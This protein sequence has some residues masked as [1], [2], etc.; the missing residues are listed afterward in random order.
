MILSLIAICSG[1]GIFMLQRLNS[2]KRG[3]SVHL[4]EFVPKQSR[5]FVYAG[6]LSQII[7]S[8]HFPK[9]YQ[10]IFIAI[11]PYQS[12]R[13]LVV[14]DTADF[15]LCQKVTQQQEQRLK[16]FLNQTVFPL[17]PPKIRNYR[18][19][20]LYFYSGNDSFFVCTF[21]SGTFVGS[22][23]F[24][25]FQS[26]LNA[27]Y[28]KTGF[29]CNVQQQETIASYL[30]AEKAVFISRQ[31]DSFA[32]ITVEKGD[33]W[34]S[35]AGFDTS[36]AIVPNQKKLLFDLDVLPDSLFSLQ[37]GDQIEF[38]FTDAVLRQIQGTSYRL[39]L[40]RG[41]GSVK[42]LSVYPL[43]NHILLI[44]SIN[45]GDAPR[46]QM[47]R[48]PFSSF[49]GIH[50]LYEASHLLKNNNVGNASS[51]YWSQWRSY[52]V[53]S[54]DING[55]IRYVRDKEKNREPAAHPYIQNHLHDLKGEM[56][57]TENT[58]IQSPR[59]LTKSLRQLLGVK[60]AK[61][62]VKYDQTHVPH[63]LQGDLEPSD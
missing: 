1:I 59:F 9:R 45:H 63:L 27:Y 25:L 54:T 39:F 37:F 58:D 26:V 55:I 42:G 56:F 28:S 24:Q 21:L 48:V 17:F 20:K 62:V 11:S 19:T 22:Y 46:G 3:L 12:N 33:G 7:S 61:M 36:S 5:T 50:S 14:C 49:L 18:G 23:N 8:A 15:V 53:L 43:K 10:K 35:I 40:C 32:A 4:F 2:D 44:D 41:E 47:E 30:A 6:K 13:A 34:H 31:P 60:H 38:P 57:F 51:I 29:K 52:L 16:T